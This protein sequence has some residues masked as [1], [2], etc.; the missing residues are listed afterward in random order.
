MTSIGLKLI[1]IKNPESVI[2]FKKVSF[3]ISTPKKSA[4]SK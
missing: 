1:I 4:K 2:V 3:K